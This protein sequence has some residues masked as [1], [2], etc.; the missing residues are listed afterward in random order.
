MCVYIA[1]SKCLPLRCLIPLHAAA[2]PLHC[3]GRI[4]RICRA[5]GIFV[6]QFNSN[7]TCTILAD[8]P[9]TLIYFISYGA[10]FVSL[11]PHNLL[12]YQVACTQLDY[13][14]S[15]FHK[16]EQIFHREK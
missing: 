16:D 7:S 11:I 13:L 5:L 3:R 12:T 14:S 15:F 8:L 9:N 6:P 1:R 4:D 10:L 2:I